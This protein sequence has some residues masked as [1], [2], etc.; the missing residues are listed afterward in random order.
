MFGSGVLESGDNAGGYE[1]EARVEE[2][3]ESTKKIEAYPG[4]RVMGAER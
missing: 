4:T 1:C 3:T 2:K